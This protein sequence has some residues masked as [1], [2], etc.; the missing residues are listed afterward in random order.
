[1]SSSTKLRQIVVQRLLA[2]ANFVCSALKRHPMMIEVLVVVA[3]IESAPLGN[4]LD[5]VADS[6][7]FHLGSIRVLRKRLSHQRLLIIIGAAVLHLPI[8]ALGELSAE[9][10]LELEA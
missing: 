6:A 7:L 8:I 10:L 2:D 4:F 5:Y 9:A 3:I 1:L